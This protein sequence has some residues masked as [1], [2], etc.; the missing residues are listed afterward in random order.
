MRK[1]SLII[2]SV[3]T[4]LSFSDSTTTVAS[5]MSI[6]VRYIRESITCGTHETPGHRALHMVEVQA[7]D[8][9]N[10]NV[11][12]GKGRSA[13]AYNGVIY[14]HQGNTSAPNDLDLLT[15]GNLDYRYYNETRPSES[16]ERCGITLDIGEIKEINKIKSWHYYNDSRKYSGY[17]LEV[18]RDGNDWI[19]VY[20]SDVDGEY[21]ETV[22]GK[23]FSMPTVPLENTINISAN[24]DPYLEVSLDTNNI[25]FTISGN[26]D[27]KVINTSVISN[28]N[29]NV[30]G[31]FTGLKASSSETTLTDSVRFIVDNEIKDVLQDYSS[32]ISNCNLG[33]NSHTLSIEFIN[34]M[35]IKSDVYTGIIELKVSQI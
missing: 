13:I 26:S 18:S 35:N 32:L 33:D 16:V 4:L 15:D 17:K 14:D 9:S 22:D 28:M 7:F 25:D 30:D 12:S 31:K 2:L 3:V 1:I 8:S 29:Y 19:T 6:P 10:T 24:V 34:S 27:S 21:V 23:E 5:G 20:N 11:L